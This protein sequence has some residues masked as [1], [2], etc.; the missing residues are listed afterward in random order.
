MNKTG[1][2]VWL[3]NQMSSTSMLKLF[4]GGLGVAIL[5]LTTGL[6]IGQN[7]APGNP[8]PEP[9][10]SMSIPTGYSAH[11]S[12]DLGGHMTNVNGSQAM[13]STLVNMG[14][15]PRV[16][17]ESFELHALPGTKNPVVDSLK[18]YGSGFGGDP[19]SFGK[20]DFFKGKIFE[21]SG[22]FRRDRQYF[23][24]DL[25]GNPNIAPGS[26]PIGPSNSPT[27]ALSWGVIPQS[28]VMFNSVRRMT[29]T[30][31]TLYPLST[32]SY[33]IGYAHNTFEGPTLSPSY[34]IA[35]YDALLKEFQRNGI[36]AFTGAVEW[37]PVQGTRLTFEA[38]VDHYRSDSQFMMAP[39]T[40]IAQEADG[41]RVALGN[42]DSQTPYGIGGCTTTSMGSAYTSSSNYTILTAAQTPNGL[43]VI[44]PACAVVT[45][46]M[47]SQPTSLMI[48]TGIIH[49]QSSS[50]RNVTMNGNVR[51][52]NSTMNMPNYYEGVTGLMGAVRSIT[53]NG[54]ARAHRAVLGAD[55][56]L[57]WQAM[58]TV[59]LAEQVD[60]SNVQ[61][62]GYSNL[63]IATTLSTPLDTK[64]SSGNETITY[65]GPLTGGNSMSLPHGVNGYLTPNY[66][67][68]RFLIN[69]LT[70]SWEVSPR[71]TLSLTYRYSMHDIAQGASHSGPIP[72]ALADPVNGTVSITENG[73]ILGAAVRVTNNWS[74]NGSAEVAYADNAFTSVS[75]RQLKQFRIRTIFKP[76]PWATFSGAYNDRE[77]HN[78]TFNNADAIAAGQATYYGP[79][80]HIDFSRVANVNA[81]LAPNEHYG[82]DLSYSY[83]DVYTATNICFTSGATSTLPG[84]ATLNNAGQPNVCPGIFARGGTNLVDFFAKD[85]VDAPTQFGSMSLNVSP[86]DNVHLNF[87]YHISAV[88]GDRFYNDARDVAGSLIS[89]YQSP[90]ANISWKTSRH[91]TWK[92][93]YNNYQ[94]GEGGSASGAQ[95]CSM[96]VTTT[97]SV[98]PCASVSFP[99]GRTE[100]TSGLT[101]ARSFHANNMTLG[102]H[103][104]F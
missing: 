19:Y 40:L 98:V 42:W 35:K 49:L 104:E 32:V 88:N 24:Y 51:Y 20:V 21:F 77:R 78:N 82:I 90:F 13:Y 71:T 27:G 56:G 53:Y 44:N 36:D 4:A 76:K 2:F 7:P 61:Q 64:A 22:I 46:Y 55:Y 41:R 72:L 81:M 3:A 60:F 75:P 38:Q 25:L 9:A 14:S 86:S 73:G 6:A 65:S 89:T 74:V 96:S 28:P 85:F 43:P 63:P 92:G 57:I 87:G 54:Y 26:I 103:Y 48:P 17:G 68:Q 1:R 34:T 15:G 18:A 33:R 102:V 59:S 31:L 93:D 83:T 16:L 37:K 12:V 69:N 47:R 52:S 23:D 30:N 99:T 39:S 66:F 11:E 84:A 29:D 79:L 80:N 100:G 67:G 45:S 58:K 70:G 5:L 8:I 101:S 95:Y 97:T 91:L 62:P 50:F 10:V 94:Y